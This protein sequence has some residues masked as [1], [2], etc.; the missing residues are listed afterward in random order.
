[1]RKQ[2]NVANGRRIGEQHDHAIHT[3]PEPG[4]GRHPIL[5]RANI[6]GVV[7]HGLLVAGFLALD[8]ILEALRLILG[9]VEL[10]ETVGELAAGDDELEALG[11]G[12]A[13]DAIARAREDGY[14][15]AEGRGGTYGAQTVRV[16]RRWA[17]AEPGAPSQRESEETADF[18]PGNVSLAEELYAV[19]ACW[20]SAEPVTGPSPATFAEAARV[21]ALCDTV[22]DQ[23]G[24]A[25]PVAVTAAR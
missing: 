8:L 18:G 7:V 3:Q 13:R 6:V 25:E 23:I 10:G 12:E 24:R 11:L 1:V 16:G 19:I 5:E 20:S 17:W 9:I 15:I 4:G 2:Q 14:A 21:T 22:Y